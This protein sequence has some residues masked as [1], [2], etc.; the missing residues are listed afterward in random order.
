[1]AEGSLESKGT[2]IIN[3]LNRSSK[4][5]R[6]DKKIAFFY[7]AFIVRVDS[8]TRKKILPDTQKYS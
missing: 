5:R 4:I 3:I 1:M 8:P 2:Y 6:L 7:K